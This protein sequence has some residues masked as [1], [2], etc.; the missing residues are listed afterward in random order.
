MIMIVFVYFFLRPP[1]GDPDTAYIKYDAAKL[2]DFEFK[3]NEVIKL[4]QERINWLLKGSRRVRT[5]HCVHSNV[6]HNR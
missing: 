6:F 1:D 3:I 5:S 2:Q 4:C